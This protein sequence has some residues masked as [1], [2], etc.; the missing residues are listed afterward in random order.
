MKEIEYRMSK[1]EKQV[2]NSSKK[3]IID[4]ILKVANEDIRHFPNLNQI[5]YV[6]RLLSSVASILLSLA[7]SHFDVPM[8]NFLP[9]YFE[10][11][12]KNISIKLKQLEN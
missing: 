5:D 9:Q 10:S 7:I 6:L 3:I 8:L 11:L 4:T 1:E 12:E 2:F